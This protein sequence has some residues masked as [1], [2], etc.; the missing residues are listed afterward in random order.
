MFITSVLYQ[1]TSVEK[2]ITYIQRLG[3]CFMMSKI[4]QT[5]WAAFQR[6]LF[7]VNWTTLQQST[8]FC[9]NNTSSWSWQ[10]TLTSWDTPQW[11]HT[12]THTHTMSVAWED[13]HPADKHS[14]LS[15]ALIRGHSHFRPRVISRTGRVPVVVG[16]VWIRGLQ[17]QW[18]LA[19]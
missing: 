17:S 16:V 7:E 9:W 11:G 12:H 5:L 3:T 19:K 13:K 8:H 15:P 10:Y 2:S 6:F 18:P 4:L 1:F 14:A